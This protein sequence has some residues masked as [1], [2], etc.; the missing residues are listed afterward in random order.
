MTTLSQCCTYLVTHASTGI[1]DHTGLFCSAAYAKPQPITA[2][3]QSLLSSIVMCRIHVIPD[4]APEP[5]APMADV[6][7]A[8]SAGAA[9]MEGGST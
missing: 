5:A 6:P 3:E 1:D 2:L 4:P 8:D 9:A 7:P